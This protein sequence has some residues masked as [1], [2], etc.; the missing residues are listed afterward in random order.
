MAADH[1]EAADER[2]V[3]RIRPMER[4][5]R[6]FVYT[7]P[8]RLRLAVAI[9]CLVGGSALGLIYP[10]FFGELAN[11]AFTQ[12]FADAES[13]ASARSMLGE[14]TAVLVA[15]FLGQAVFV[16]FRHYLMT[17]L[18]ERVVA[19]IRVSLYR[20]LVTMPQSFFHRTRTG[21]LLSRLGDDVT[22]LQDTVG[23]DLS[24]AL[25]NLLTLIGGV[26]ILLV[27]NTKLTLAMLVVVPGIVIAAGI[28]SRIIR[29][30][31][32]EAQ[33]AL[34][35]ANGELQEGLAAIETVQAFTREDY[36]VRRYG[37]AIERTFGLFIH[38]ALARSWFSAVVSFLFFAA[39]AGI[40]WMGGS[41]VLNQEI[42]VGEFTSFIFYTMMVAAAVG[43]FGEL[44]SGL[45]S[46]FGATARIFEILDEQPEIKDPPR[47]IE[48][49]ALR[50]E[51][52]FR[53]VS[54]SYADRDAAVL[55]EIDLHVQPGQV[56]ALVGPSGSGKT[57]VG[58]LLLRFWDPSGG[59]IE[60]DGHDIRELRLADLRGVMALVSQDPVLFS[61][62]IR[63]NIRYGQLEASEDE[64]VAAALAAN[65]DGFI[66]E[67]PDGYDTVVG[68]R[69]VKLSG[70][71]RQRI[72]IARA[73]LRDP[74]ILV[75]DEATSALDSESEHLVQE[76]LEKL[77]HGRTTVVIA[78][79]LSTIRD[80]DIIVVLAAGRIVERGRHD[81]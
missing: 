21:E 71:Q 49:P 37:G 17:W 36:E 40:F 7:R 22:R 52:V 8:Y 27:T 78:H 15:V 26:V 33:D 76:A 75:L 48:A 1:P 31:S 5:R 14:T 57:T 56:C 34:A 70:G 62:S 19:D 72:S 64:I 25:R 65:A 45:Q 32:R 16:F 2:P 44:F 68:E 3:D 6:L 51:L 69:G 74:K 18:G 53:Q 23:Q 46:T 24:M 10:Y 9:L 54:F 59:R 80:A 50:G 11:V 41:M 67:F 39:I 60:I 58:R 77:Q 28:W 30:L 73:I 29:R 20:H 38:R 43:T 55:R 42:T 4:L 79:R 12:A 61:G 35:R 81:E 66:R 13:L 63:E 47:P